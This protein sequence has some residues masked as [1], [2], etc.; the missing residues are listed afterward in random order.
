MKKIGIAVL[1]GAAFLTAACADTHPTA[2]SADLAPSY[3][4][5]DAGT[6]G[7]KLQCFAED[8]ASCSLIQNG[9][10]LNTTSGGYAGVYIGNSNLNG[11]LLSEINKFSFTYSGTGVTGGS[12]RIT[13]PIDIDGDGVTVYDG[14]D[15]YVTIDALGCGNGT[16]TS[17]TVDPINNSSCMVSLN[18]GPTYANW[19]AFLAAYPNARVASN[20]PFVIVDQP[21]QFTITNVQLG[22][23]AAKSKG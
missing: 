9:A 23:G 10:S 7:N 21:G 5:G 1:A 3:A 11:R 2:T 8:G 20:L 22:R 13:F 19:A 4:R 12:P 6:S 16:A 17:G 15:D 18:G 14:Y